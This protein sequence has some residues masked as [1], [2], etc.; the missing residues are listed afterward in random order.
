MSDAANMPTVASRLHEI[1][2]DVAEARKLVTDKDPESILGLIIEQ[3]SDKAK[4]LDRDVLEYER[5]GYVEE[6]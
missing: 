3:I 4:R 2:D 6:K 1:A 5:Y